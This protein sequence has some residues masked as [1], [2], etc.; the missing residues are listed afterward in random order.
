VGMGGF[1]RV[2]LDMTATFRIGKHHQF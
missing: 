2:H 1:E